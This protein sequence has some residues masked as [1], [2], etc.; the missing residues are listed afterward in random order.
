MLRAR[1]L[2]SCMLAS[3]LA[4][5]GCHEI[6]FDPDRQSLEIDIFDD[7]FAVSVVGDDHAVAAGYWRATGAR[8]I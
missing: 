2:L 4:T 1:L 6:D 5:G 8:S 7:L 3:G